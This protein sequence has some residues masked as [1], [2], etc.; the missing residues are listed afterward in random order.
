MPN[1][2]AGTYR[3]A[4]AALPRQFW[5]DYLTT[6]SGLPGPRA[7]LELIQVA[8]DLGTP[9]QFKRW[10]TLPDDYLPVCGAVGLGRLLAEGDRTVLPTLRT[11]A[12]DGRWRLREGVAM[13]LQRWGDADMESLVVVMTTWTA[14]TWLE[15]RAAAAALCEPRLLKDNTFAA[16]RT[17]QL[18]DQMTRQLSQAPAAARKDE[19]FKTLRQGLAYCWSVAA[20]ALPAEGLPA[21][22]AWLA[23]PQLDPDVSWLLQQNLQKHRLARLD[24]AWVQ[25]WLKK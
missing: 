1:A 15:Q 17:L 14:G 19:A 23:Q 5:D 18:L 16:R 7:N 3:L 6:N 21:L 24:P 20:A 10:I 2:T 12:N 13:A 25:R 22:E 8:A 9:A 11:L 4:L